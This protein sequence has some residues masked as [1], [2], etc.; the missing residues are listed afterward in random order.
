MGGTMEKEFW[1][2]G[3]VRREWATSMLTRKQA[4]HEQV[5]LI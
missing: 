5:V 1:T 3:I 4:R 2:Q